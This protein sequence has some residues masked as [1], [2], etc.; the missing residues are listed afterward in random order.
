VLV[1]IIITCVV[2][3]LGATLLL[4]NAVFAFVRPG[5]WLAAKWTFTRGFGW[6]K[7][8][9]DLAAVQGF[10]GLMLIGGLICLYAAI[11]VTAE[12]WFLLG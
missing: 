6:C 5:R 9:E 10:A 2:F 1:K 4:V 8:P 11:R 3:W 12:A 7:S